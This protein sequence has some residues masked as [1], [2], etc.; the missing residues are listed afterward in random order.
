MI[1]QSDGGGTND[2]LASQVGREI[3]VTIDRWSLGQLGAKDLILAAVVLAVGGCAAWLASRVARRVARRYE[4]A[5]RAAIAAT[6]LALGSTIATFAVAVTLEVLGFSLAPLLVLLLLLV[7]II[8]LLRPLM[9]NLSSGFLLQLR[10]ALA[11]GDVVLT[12]DVLGTV[13]EIN[14]RTVVLHTSDGRRVHVPN[15]V[16]LDSTI[17]N[18]SATGKRRSSFDLTVDASVDLDRMITTVE[19]VVRDCDGVLGDPPPEV[20]A[21]EIV[22][23]F[24]VLRVFVWHLPP[25]AVQRAVV[26]ACVRAVLSACAADGIELTGPNWIAME[27]RSSDGRSS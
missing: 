27:T 24:V 22:G 7:A 5:Q 13:H 16:V 20:Q 8:L 1:R 15:A 23:P 2:D 21:R 3:S 11:A 17:D 9:T 12:N 18:Y 4:G 10:R 19:R 26:D 6:G 25:L 14:A